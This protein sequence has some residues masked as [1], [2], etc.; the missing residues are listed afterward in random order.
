M[1]HLLLVLVLVVMGCAETVYTPMGTLEYNRKNWKHWLDFDKDGQ[2][3]RQEVLIAEN[4]ASDDST[5]YNTDSSRIIKG[6][7]V[8]AYTGDSVTNPSKL[9]VDHM[10]P[11][12]EAFVSGGKYWSMG[13]KRAFANELLSSDDHLI[14]VTASSNR[15]KGARD[16]AHWMPENNKCWYLITWLDI[17]GRWKLDMDEE[18]QMFIDI[19]LDENCGCDDE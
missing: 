14:A 2:D 19:Y 17:K 16:P 3:T 4:L 6:L 7:W 13:Q 1:K 12:K 9:D 18:E 11:L 10:I 5:E 8:C 15:S